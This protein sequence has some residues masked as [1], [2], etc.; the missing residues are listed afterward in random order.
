[1]E[2]MGLRRTNAFAAFAFLL[3]AGSVF[4]AAEGENCNFASDCPSG[5][6][7]IIPSNATIA[8]TR[9]LSCVNP[10]K[11]ATYKNETSYEFS[12]NDT[13]VLAKRSIYVVP[14]KKM[15]AGLSEGNASELSV[16]VLWVHNGGSV[17]VTGDLIERVPPQAVPSSFQRAL[18]FSPKPKSLSYEAGAVVASWNVSIAP[19]DSLIVQ[20]V[21]PR[22]IVANDSA[23]Y[24]S[25]VIS[26][27]SA[28]L[29]LSGISSLVSSQG[30]YLLGALAL[31]V[32]LFVAASAYGAGRSSASG[33]QSDS[34]LGAKIHK[35]KDKLWQH[36]SDWQ[37]NA[38]KLKR[39]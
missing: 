34:V 3:L 1:M 27:P 12:S 2:G 21:V 6:L 31:I 35:L 19:A 38:D 20:Y 15:V 7:C 5:F 28:P 18:A 33:S 26:E 14:Y 22:G 16:V 9:A 13:A 23:A 36:P 37:R 32:I 25:P 4:A 17:N 39:M 8:D 11:A 30:S 24:S 29:D 10:L